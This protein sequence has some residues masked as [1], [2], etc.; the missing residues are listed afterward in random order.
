MF[1]VVCV[2]CTHKLYVNGQNKYYI[3]CT[4]IICNWIDILKTMATTDLILFILVF[5]M[6]SIQNVFIICW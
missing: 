2:F 1:K 6:I 5:L 4:I 3:I